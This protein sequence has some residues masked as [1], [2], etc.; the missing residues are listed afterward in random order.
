[1]S[2]HGVVS[3]GDGRDVQ[4]GARQSRQSRAR[5]HDLRLEP[6]TDFMLGR[7]DGVR[8][9]ACPAPLARQQ[10]G[11]ARRTAQSPRVLLL[12]GHYRA[13]KEGC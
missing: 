5:E 6:Q 7:L 3:K 8:A 4:E 10:E 2:M 1:M 13:E 11:Q 12:V 9:V